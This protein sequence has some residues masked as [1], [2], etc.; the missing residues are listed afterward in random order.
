MTISNQG[1]HRDR[2]THIGQG[3][4]V[5]KGRAAHADDPSY[6]FMIGGREFAPGR[7][8]AQGPTPT[9]SALSPI[10]MCCSSSR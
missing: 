4:M 1:G 9:A 10:M 8:A 7:Q 5:M 6:K 2:R 3:R